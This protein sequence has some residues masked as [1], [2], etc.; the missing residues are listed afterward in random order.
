M[1]IKR[2]KKRYTNKR[3]STQN[4]EYDD[5]LQIKDEVTKMFI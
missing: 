2:K 1:D 5:N 3:I 4:Y